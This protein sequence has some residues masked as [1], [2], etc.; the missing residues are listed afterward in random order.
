MRLKTPICLNSKGNEIITQFLFSVGVCL[1]LSNH[2]HYMC[3]YQ[4]LLHHIQVNWVSNDNVHQSMKIISS[5]KNIHL[6]SCMA[7]EKEGDLPLNMCSILQNN[8][9][10]NIMKCVVGCCM[11]IIAWAL[12]QMGTQI[13]NGM[14]KF[15]P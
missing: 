1:L 10:N 5:D 11:F 13:I 6:S 14:T 15:T 12:K 8:S 2:C 7:R 9:Y 3:C 4:C